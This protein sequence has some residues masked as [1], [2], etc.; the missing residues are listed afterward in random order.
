MPR[1]DVRHLLDILIGV[2]DN[3]WNILDGLDP[4]LVKLMHLFEVLQR[5]H[6]RKQDIILS[7]DCDSLL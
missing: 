3:N 1:V 2:N 7:C 4:L 6:L 5:H